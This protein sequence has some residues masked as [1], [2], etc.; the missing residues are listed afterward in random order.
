M[1]HQELTMKRV[2]IQAETRRLQAGGVATLARSG[3]TL[4]NSTREQVQRPTIIGQKI[5]FR[6]AGRGL[7]KW[8][9]AV[10]TSQ[11]LLLFFIFFVF[12]CSFRDINEFLTPTRSLHH[13]PLGSCVPAGIVPAAERICYNLL[14]RKQFS[15]LWTTARSGSVVFDA[16]GSSNC[17]FSAK[18]VLFNALR[19]T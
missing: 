18:F 1:D 3:S 19:L 4:R 9:E 15:I 11:V 2:Y 8:R 13:L 14:P 5:R 12:A 16:L 6:H 17:W 7:Q 10:I